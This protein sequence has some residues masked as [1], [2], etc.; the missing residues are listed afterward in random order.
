MSAPTPARH[1]C[2]LAS[3][4]PRRSGPEI[5]WPISEFLDGLEENEGDQPLTVDEDLQLLRAC[6]ITN[7]TV[8]W[9]EY[10]ELVMGGCKAGS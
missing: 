2:D 3:G 5:D 6:G 9:Q 7:A 1:A 4:P 10:R 8:F